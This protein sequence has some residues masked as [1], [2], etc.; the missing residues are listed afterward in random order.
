MSYKSYF[1]RQDNETLVVIPFNEEHKSKGYTPLLDHDIG[2]LVMFNDSFKTVEIHED[3]LAGCFDYVR[4]DYKFVEY[5]D[6][7]YK[8]KSCQSNDRCAPTRP[9]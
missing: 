9:E 2:H 1:C 5:I 6:G 3:V 4:Q 8:Y 7:F